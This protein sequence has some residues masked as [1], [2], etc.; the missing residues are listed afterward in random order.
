MLQSAP[1]SHSPAHCRFHSQCPC[2][3]V[4]ASPAPL[5]LFASKKNSRSHVPQPFLY[6]GWL[7]SGACSGWLWSGAW[8][9]SWSFSRA[10]AGRST[11]LDWA[12]LD[13]ALLDGA[14]SST[15]TRLSLALFGRRS[16]LLPFFECHCLLRNSAR[17]AAASPADHNTRDML[18]QTRMHKPASVWKAPVCGCS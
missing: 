18:L 14:A 10:S 5:S 6:A 11:L 9:C 17:S 15:L 12:L 1:K 8:A 2:A 4:C 7:W 3:A 16:P 13:G